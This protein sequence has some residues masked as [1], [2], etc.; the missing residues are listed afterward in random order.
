LV[1]PLIELVVKELRGPEYSPEDKG[2]NAEDDLS[3]VSMK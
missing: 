1:P 2:N 3:N